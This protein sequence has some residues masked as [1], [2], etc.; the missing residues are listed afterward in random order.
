MRKLI[1][2]EFMS[3]DGV[4]EAPDRWHMSYVDAEMFAVMWPDGGDV[5]T[6]LLGRTTY[7]SFAGAFADGPA[8][9]PVVANMNRPT[10]VVVTSNPST[11]TWKNSTALTG[12]AVAG[13]RALKRGDGGPI[14]VIGSTRLARTLLAAGLVDELSLLLHPL[15]VGSGERLFPADGPGATFTLAGA[16]PLRSG[17]VHLTYRAAA[18]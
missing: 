7:D 10:K 6:L 18:S 4:V 13:V 9:D 12:E 11:V 3:L 15:V 5:D 2:A 17:V 16:T 8:D 14:A 1:L